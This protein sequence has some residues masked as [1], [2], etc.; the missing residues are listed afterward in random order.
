MKK[1]TA[2]VLTPFETQNIVNSAACLLSEIEAFEEDKTLVNRLKRLLVQI[3]EQLPEHYTEKYVDYGPGSYHNRLKRCLAYKTAG[4]C[5][6]YS[7]GTLVYNYRRITLPI[8]TPTDKAVVKKIQEN[9]A[10]YRKTFEQD[11]SI[12]AEEETK[13]E[14]TAFDKEFWKELNRTRNLFMKYQACIFLG[15]NFKPSKKFT[16]NGKKLYELVDIIKEVI[17]NKY[18]IQVLDRSI[19]TAI[20]HAKNLF[21][22]HGVRLGINSFNSTDDLSAACKTKLLYQPTK[23]CINVI[24]RRFW[25]TTFYNVINDPDIGGYSY[26]TPE[27]YLVD[28]VYSLQQ[29]ANN[30][31]LD[32]ELKSFL[33]VSGIIKPR[34]EEKNV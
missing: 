28:W 23:N 24:E 19:S 25:H 1:D 30:N 27:R 12:T 16:L 3:F 29:L 2:A 14:I 20:T 11:A 17:K 10:G 9:T 8:W 5:E 22:K 26:Y 15:K 32:P 31:S 21:Q 18:D 13:K 7:D 34:E 6:Y 33:E 4:I